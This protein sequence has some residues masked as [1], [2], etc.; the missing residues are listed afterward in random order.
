MRILNRWRLDGQRESYENSSNHRG[1][2]DSPL[3]PSPAAD[4]RL[5]PVASSGGGGGGE[6]IPQ[7]LRALSAPDGVWRGGGER[8]WEGLLFRGK[9]IGM[10]QTAGNC[11]SFRPPQRHKHE[12]RQCVCACA[13]VRVRVCMDCANSQLARRQISIKQVN[14]AGGE[15]VTLTRKHDVN[16]SV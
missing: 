12:R 14:A 6:G 16:I 9:R 3:P 2:A 11:R 10:Y 8:G 4:K 5:R 7:K 15:G 13:R 1:F